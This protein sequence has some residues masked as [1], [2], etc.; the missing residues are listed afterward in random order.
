MGQVIGQSNR[1]AAEPQTEPIRNPSLIAT[2]LNTVMDIGQV[3]LVRGLP[4]DI[5]TAATAAD[6]IPGLR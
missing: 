2:V 3:R 1:M 6:P 5:V 4:A